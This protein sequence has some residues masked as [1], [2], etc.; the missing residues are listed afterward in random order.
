[1]VWCSFARYDTIIEGVG[2]DRLTAN[3]SEALID[4]AVRCSDEEAV[5]MSRQ[6]L[7]NEGMFVGS[8]SAMHCVGAVKVA[9]SLGPGLT[10]VTLLCDSGQRHISRLW[11]PEFLATHGLC[12]L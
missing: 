4:D 10:I 6:L 2:L 11:N 1:M 8:S 7:K 12:A 3:F 5:A 9:H